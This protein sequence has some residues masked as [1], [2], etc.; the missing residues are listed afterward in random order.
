[1]GLALG[2]GRSTPKGQIFKKNLKIK[3]FLA[4][5]G[6]RTTPKGHGEPPHC[7]LSFILI[8]NFLLFLFSF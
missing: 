4:L 7:F 8:F 1:M 6:G 5:G 3:I 2:G